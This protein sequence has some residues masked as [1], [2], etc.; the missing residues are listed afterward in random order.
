MA[1]HAL[2]SEDPGAHLDVNLRV[3]PGRGKLRLEALRAGGEDRTHGN[4]RSE[5][6]RR[7]HSR[8]SHLCS[9]SWWAEALSFARP[10][11]SVFGMA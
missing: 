7:F 3:R 2:R 9:P 4:D 6:P 1:D 11:L 5:D 8:R 10:A